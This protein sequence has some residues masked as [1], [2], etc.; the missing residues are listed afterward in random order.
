M[1]TRRDREEAASKRKHIKP[2]DIPKAAC[3]HDET[4]ALREMVAMP[5]KDGVYST[6]HL[7][8]HATD[9]HAQN[10]C[11]VSTAVHTFAQA[12]PSYVEAV[13]LLLTCKKVYT[14]SQ[15]RRTAARLAVKGAHAPEH[16]NSLKAPEDFFARS[17]SPLA[18]AS[19]GSSTTTMDT[20]SNQTNCKRR[21]SYVCVGRLY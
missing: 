14:T 6:A 17:S 2:R 21:A 19:T 11:F 7:Y 16:G 8:H 1:L 3:E 5:W 15:S 9:A 4:V 13:Y 10:G 20:L 12:V 18:N